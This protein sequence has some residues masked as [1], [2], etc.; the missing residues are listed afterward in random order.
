MP[1]AAGFRHDLPSNPRLLDQLL[2]PAIEVLDNYVR[3]VYRDGPIDD[4]RFVRLG[5]CRV[6]SQAASGRDFL[7]M[8]EEMLRE[9]VAR[10]SF[11]D[12]LHATR[13]LRILAELN[14]ELVMRQKAATKDLLAGFP[15][16]RDVPVFAVDG[17]HVE[18]AVHSPD[19]HKGQKVSSNNLYLL[20]LHSA[21]LWNLGAVQGDGRHGHEMPV[22]RQRIAQWLPQ[23][24]VRRGRPI[25]IFVG[26]PAFVDKVFW[27][28]MAVGSTRA[29]FITR[30]KANMK[31]IVYGP[32]RWD[33]AAPVNEGVT[34]DVTVGFDGAATMR[35]VRYTDPET[36][37]E[38]EFLTSVEDLAPGLIAL[39]YLTRWRIEKV[40]DT[41]KNKLEETKS[42]AVGENAQEIR[43]HFVALTHNLLVL[44]RAELER[45]H[46]VRE[47]KVEKKRQSQAIRRER[48]AKEAGK[49]VAGVQR[50]L[51]AV[52]QLTA[53]YV[54]AVRNG[55]L[56]G[57][58]W[59]RALAQLHAATKS[60]L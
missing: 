43:A 16:L 26:D 33:P 20:C 18:H 59:F 37:T 52:V 9:P 21:L 29:R 24:R 41:A 45:G 27:T 1:S 19:D 10:S 12:T 34:A 23:W 13:R 57:T 31:P 60:Y 8:A 35:M 51:P 15:E 44:L 50:R 39:L 48:R 53:Q 4:F 46:G 56:N 30:T 55:I 38:Y 49:K 25:P 58:R 32:R 47:E 28:R 6:L 42:W 22:F 5:V 54:R 36:G 11:F 14:A 17:H 2:S 3:G 7:Q 40:F